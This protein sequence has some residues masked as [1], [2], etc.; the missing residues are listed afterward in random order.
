MSDTLRP[1]SKGAHLAV[2]CAFRLHAATA[3]GWS[4]G[5]PADW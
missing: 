1:T 3:I 4:L 2:G 5:L